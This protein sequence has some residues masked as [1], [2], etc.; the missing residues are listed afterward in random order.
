VKIFRLPLL[1]FALILLGLPPARGAVNWLT[2]FQKAQDEAKANHKL[3]L[4]NFTGSDWCPWCVRLEREVFSKPEFES[5]AQKNLVLLMA[6]F[7]RAKPL[8]REVRRQNSELA[9]RFRVE[10]FPTIVVLNSEGKE[11]GELGYIRGGPD[12]FI[13]ELKKLPQEKLP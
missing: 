9:E 4:I 7:P 1:A 8:S 11:V 5:Y 2:D 3:L 6:D 12:A 10:G 13:S